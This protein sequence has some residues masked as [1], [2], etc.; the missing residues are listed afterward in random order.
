MGEQNKS[1]AGENQSVRRRLF[2]FL[3][4]IFFKLLYHQFAWMYD[5]VASIISLG[6]WQKWV[7]TSLPFLEGPRILEIGFGTGHLQSSLLQKGMIAFGLDESRQMINI[8]LRRLR[9]K[10]FVSGLVRGRAQNLPFGNETLDQIVLTFPAEFILTKTIFVEMHRILKS[11]GSIIII[12]LAW[13]TGQTPLDRL[14][15]WINKITGET[16]AW[17]ESY[18]S[19]FASMGFDV[20]WEMITQPSSRVLLI[21]LVKKELSVERIESSSA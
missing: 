12:P 13:I 14:A 10:G 20:H 2:G 6:S 3:L 16:P 9:K 19:P 4:S 17:D 15:I 7:N 1:V 21:R 5:G 11:N 8:S 18:I